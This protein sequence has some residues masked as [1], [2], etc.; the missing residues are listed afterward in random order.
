MI[1]LLPSK[2]LPKKKYH[3][4]FYKNELRDFSNL[5]RLFVFFLLNSFAKFSQTNCEF[6]RIPPNISDRIIA[7]QQNSKYEMPVN[8]II[9]S[10]ST[11]QQ[12]FLLFKQTNWTIKPQKKTRYEMMWINRII[13]TCIQ[14]NRMPFAIGHTNWKG[15]FVES[16]IICVFFFCFETVKTLISCTVIFFCRILFIKW[17]RV[18]ICSDS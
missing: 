15:N 17:S 18:V 8:V 3:V 11:V 1:F 2:N 4:I 12:S 14:W 10:E 5:F 7:S 6:A 16:S 9:H 13:S